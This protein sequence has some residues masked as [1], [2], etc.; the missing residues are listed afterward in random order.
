[1]DNS[2]VVKELNAFLEGNYMAVLSYERY[3]Q[4]VA[5]QDIKKVLQ[6]IQKDHKY[7]AIRVAERIQN[8]GGVPADDAGI[9][10]SM[11]EFMNRFKKAT[12]D[13]NF[14]LQDAIKGEDKG[15]QMSEQLVRGDLDPESQK[16]VKD[17]LNE[18]RQHLDQ[19]NHYVH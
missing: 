14:I 5:D 11:V 18:D 8:L 6:D 4:H 12:D 16:L 1:M 19:L 3:I 9:Q 2:D 17:I 15:I 10:G 7:H 13:P